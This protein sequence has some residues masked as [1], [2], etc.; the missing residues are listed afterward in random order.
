MAQNSDETRH[1][2][3]EHGSYITH[4]GYA[5]K[6]ETEISFR[7]PPI[8]IEAQFKNIFVEV[9]NVDPAQHK[10]V[11]VKDAGTAQQVLRDEAHILF[12]KFRVK[13]CAFVNAQV[14]I[15]YSWVRGSNGLIIDIGYESTIIVPIIELM[16]Q[17]DFIA[18]FPMAGRAI[19]QFIIGHL[20]KHGIEKDIIENHREQLFPYLMRDYFYFDSESEHDFEREAIE[21]RRRELPKYISLQDKEGESIEFS[22]PS[23]VLPLDLIVE[24]NDSHHLSF[25]KEINNHIIKILEIFGVD[26]L[27]SLIEFDNT[28]WWVGSIIIT[29]GASNILGLRSLLIREL[30]KT[31]ELKRYTECERAPSCPL[32][33]LE[34][35][36]VAFTIRNVPPEHNDSIW[37]GASILSSL[38]TFKRFFVSKET[39]QN[40][41]DIFFL[42]DYKVL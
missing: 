21:K 2:L 35:R 25:S 9:L 36:N 31:T 20:I 32:V 13:A 34:F 42:L 6:D 1:I 5:G 16:T 19:E 33:D 24:K 15:F 22:L 12:T 11:I 10:I 29:G 30:L 7:T 14:G 18:A 17:I 8:S 38:S 37:L 40:N 28:S 27:G 3:I 23:P 4:C 39:Y 41:S 26:N